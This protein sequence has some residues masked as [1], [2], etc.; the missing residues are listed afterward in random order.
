[1]HIRPL[2]HSG[3][4]NKKEHL[5]QYCQKCN[6]LGQNCRN[7][8]PPSEPANDD[9]NE[10]E[11]EEEDD[12]SVMSDVSD[13]DTNDVDE[14]PTPVPSDEEANEEFLSSKLG[15]LALSQKK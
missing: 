7:Y 9:D 5:T 1:M 4:R 13:V 6:E 2:L 8:I 11:E 3:D 12:V 15:N 10:E 14:V